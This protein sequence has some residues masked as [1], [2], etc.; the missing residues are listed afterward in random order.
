MYMKCVSKVIYGMAKVAV[1]VGLGLNLVGCSK[2][3]FSGDT[4]SVAASE[5]LSPEVNASSLS[6]ATL[7][8][9]TYNKNPRKC[10]QI[11]DKCF[12]ETF[13]QPVTNTGSVDVLFVVQTS[14]AISPERAAIAAGIT[15]FIQSLPVGA[16]FNIAVMLAHGSTSANS[17]RLFQAG[18]EPVV[19]KSSELSN[20]D[21]QTYLNAKLS[22]V[23]ADPDSG[24]GEEGMFS[25]FN[26]VTTPALLNAIQAQD[27]FRTDA[28]L[29]VIFV[30]DRR[31][32]C[33]VVPVGVPAETDPVKIDARIRDCE[34]LTAAGL[35][36]RLNLLK[37]SMPLAVSGIIYADEP[38]PAGNEIGYGY[39][40]MIALNAG[41]SVDIAN[42]NIA[43]GLASIA[44]LSGEQMEIQN[45][46]TLSHENIDPKKLIVTVN[47]QGV[48]YTLSGNVVTI[49][50]EVPAG[51]VVV[52]SY[53]LK[54]KVPCKHHHHGHRKC[55]KKQTWGGK[56]RH[57]NNHG[58]WYHGH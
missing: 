23:V 2:A 33:A 58:N 38:A 46:F 14:E 21:I 20:T 5:D 42:D 53:C 40:D 24:G 55:H 12:S 3:S 49:T 19:L 6:N 41:V 17:G 51:A 43:E 26:A 4:E 30:A 36:S 16:D 10:R 45:V 31:D 8:M 52:I 15:S 37:G 29:G 11:N 9:A 22:G 48:P 1:V 27:F 32:I 47:G 25:L 50:S 13:E 18:S 35:T 34:G 28:A 56:Y 39:T 44:E 7:K 57:H 54:T